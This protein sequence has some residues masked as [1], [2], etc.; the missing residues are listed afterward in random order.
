[1][2]TAQATRHLLRHT[3]TLSDNVT[4]HPNIGTQPT[5]MSRT[6]T[7]DLHP[8]ATI[9]KMYHHF[10][11]T[12]IIVHAQYNMTNAHHNQ[13][14]HTT[15]EVIDTTMTPDHYFTQETAT[16]DTPLATQEALAALVTHTTHATKDNTNHIRHTDTQTEIVIIV[17]THDA[18]NT[19]MT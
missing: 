10:P 9:T 7:V 4:I 6:T 2:P 1:M 18:T 17:T 11:A 19:A 5:I 3:M 13:D 15:K 8:V 16:P 12:K 14:V